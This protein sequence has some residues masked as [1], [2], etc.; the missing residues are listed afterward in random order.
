ML[1]KNDTLILGIKGG[2]ILFNNLKKE[3]IQADISKKELASLI[4][5]SYNTF[6]SKIKGK[7]DW[8]M[9]EIIKIQVI[10]NARNE[11]YNT[12]DDLFQK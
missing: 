8:K 5:I 3:M 12:I 9:E 11:T 7:T 2:R 4:G 6:R 10:L 1:F